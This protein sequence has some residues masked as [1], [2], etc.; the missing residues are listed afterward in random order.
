MLINIGFI[1]KTAQLSVTGELGGTLLRL[2]AVRGTFY[3]GAPT[4][5]VVGT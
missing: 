5:E 4:P 1:L 3:S 2:S